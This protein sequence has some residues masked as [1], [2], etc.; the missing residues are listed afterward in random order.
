MLMSSYD[1]L[2]QAATTSYVG[3]ALSVAPASIDDVTFRPKRRTIKAGNPLGNNR[4][5][6]RCSQLTENPETKPVGFR[7]FIIGL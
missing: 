5:G 1:S 3:S 6:N 2:G 4:G 7:V